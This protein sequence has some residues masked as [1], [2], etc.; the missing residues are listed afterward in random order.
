MA[1][2][3]LTLVDPVGGARVEVQAGGEAL[4]VVAFATWCPDCVGELERLAELEARFSGR[5]YRLVVIGV[6]TRQTAERLARFV[7]EK[8]PPGRWLFDAEGLAERALAADAL[9]LHVLFDSTGSEVAR[10]RTLD[11]AFE[12]VIEE[13]LARRGAGP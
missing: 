11:A 5:G 8:K 9:P 13:R 7:G 1:K 10:S 4:H 12:A 6:Q 2:L 3:P